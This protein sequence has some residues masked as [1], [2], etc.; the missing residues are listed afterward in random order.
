MND[1]IKILIVEDEMLIGANISLQLTSL[2]Y[3]VI[4]IVPRAEEALS[5]VEQDCPD[6]ILMDINLKGDLDG[7]ETT[8]LIKK[9]HDVAVIYLT[10][11]DDDVNFSRAKST[12]PHAFISTQIYS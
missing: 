1:P 2:G 5:C 11:N 6:I 4:G 12:H 3:E 10:A 7:V 8:K 9:S